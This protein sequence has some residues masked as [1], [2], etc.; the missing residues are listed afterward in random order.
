MDEQE[1]CRVCMPVVAYMRKNCCPHDT[2]VITDEQFKLV[3][4][5]IS[6]P[7]IECDVSDT[8]S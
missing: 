7:A 3:S 6:I 4:D 1:L 2:I 5:T 8:C